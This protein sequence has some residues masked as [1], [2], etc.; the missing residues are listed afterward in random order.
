M[1][2]QKLVSSLIT[3]KRHA[4]KYFAYFLEKRKTVTGL[5]YCYLDAKGMVPET[6]LTLQIK[7]RTTILANMEVHIS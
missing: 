7:K 4:M 2:K 6:L 3:N 1:V 5:E